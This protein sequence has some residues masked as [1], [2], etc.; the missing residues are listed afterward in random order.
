MVQGTIQRSH[1]ETPPKRDGAKE[2]WFNW[3]SEAVDSGLRGARPL[4]NALGEEKGD[5]ATIKEAKRCIYGCEE[6]GHETHALLAEDTH[7]Q[8]GIG[9]KLMESNH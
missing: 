4:H 1:V 7:D 8:I 2:Q 6:L 9:I 3:V 5:E